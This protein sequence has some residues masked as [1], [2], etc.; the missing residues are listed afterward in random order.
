M[1]NSAELETAV[2]LNLHLVVLVI[3]DNALGMIRWKQ[4]KAGFADFGLGLGNPDF[5]KYAESYGAHGHLVESTD[6]LATLLAEA[7]AG[8]GVHLIEVP[9]DYT[10][11]NDYLNNQLPAAIEKLRN[12]VGTESLVSE[13]VI[14]NTMGSK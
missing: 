13:S 5:R 8:S 12:E 10:D 3:N 14:E 11:A 7:L 9:T 1:M 4:A 2:R 6:Q